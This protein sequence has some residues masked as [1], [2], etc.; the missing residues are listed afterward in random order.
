MP[1]TPPARQELTP[2]ES[3][4]SQTAG[5]LTRKLVPGLAPDSLRARPRFFD[6]KFLTAADLTRAQSYFLTR[7]A[8]LARSLGFGVVTGLRVAQAVKSESGVAHLASSVRITG[9]HGLTPAGEAVT[10]AHDLIVDLA[11]VPQLERLNAAFGLAQKPR[12]PFG[13]LNGLFVLGLRP[14]EFTANPT[15]VFPPSLQGTQSLSDGEII[16]ATAITLVPYD[17]AA[18]VTEPGRARARA[19]RQIFFEQRPPKMPAEILPL[20]MICL[21]GGFL[22]WMD[23]F[24]VRREAGDDDRFG[25]GFAPRALAEAHF[26]HYQDLL[27]EVPAPPQRG[28]LAAA[29][30][31]E[32]LPPGGPLPAG[33]VN[34]D[35]FTQA[36]FPADARVEL[37]LV[38]EDE[39]A[40][41]MEDTLDLPPLDLG[42]KPED[43]DA[44]AI[45]VLAPVPRARYRDTVAKLT[46]LR[47]ILRNTVPALLGQQRP[48]LAIARLNQ[49][50]SVRRLI[51]TR[52]V[53][54]LSGDERSDPLARATWAGM[55]GTTPKLWYMRRRNLPFASDL[56][57]KAVPVTVVPAPPARLE[58]I[59][60]PPFQPSVL[61]PPTPV[62]IPRPPTP[63]TVTQ[64]TVTQPTVTQPTVTQPTLTQP[65]VTQPTAT[66]LD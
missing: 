24:L 19:A 2:E 13:S 17:G 38:P 27:D 33:A 31:F 61:V 54:P 58:T 43:N 6:G 55:L 66:H 4:L 9:G 7:Q 46:A 23:E 44:L 35:D 65:T 40:G 15:P 21:R 14:V 59:L 5:E 42:L 49:P 62:F 41:L 36:F 18:S 60:Q 3:Y 32:V 20:A 53:A 30:F 26:L 28:R 64:P 48:F 8:D 63:V 37:A 1:T 10:L 56:A 51:A 45:L 16:E 12:Q 39:L 52:A 57:S 29:D 25:F 11:D 50:L 22:Q 34:L 47:P